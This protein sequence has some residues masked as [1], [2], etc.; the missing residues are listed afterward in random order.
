[1]NRMGLTP[2]ELNMR[3]L[4]CKVY[5]L[6]SGN[7]PNSDAPSRWRAHFQSS[8][9]S[10]A[11]Y[12]YFASLTTTT[13]PRLHDDLRER[14]VD[15][16]DVE[17][18]VHSLLQRSSKDVP[19]REASSFD[20]LFPD[21]DKDEEKKK[22]VY[23]FDNWTIGA[24]YLWLSLHASGLSREGLRALFVILKHH[25]FDIKELPSGADELYNLTRTKLGNLVLGDFVGDSE[26]SFV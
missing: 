19:I 22:L 17:Q 10:D 21:E 12:H 5:C 1:M 26:L 25:R 3:E 15:V 16:P 18:K 20:S 24:L 9:H 4:I 11:Y 13:Q 8:H 6:P 14:K 2:G 23:P 7:C